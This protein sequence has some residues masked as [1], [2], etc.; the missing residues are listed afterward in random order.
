MKLTKKQKS[1][2]LGMV[3]GDGYLQATG[4]KNARLRLE[5]GIKQK[6]YLDWKVKNFPKLFQ[7]KIKKIN[8][9]HPVSKKVYS[10]ARHQSNS[11]PI[12]GRLR[13]IFYVDGSKLIPEYV[14]ENLDVLALAVWYMDDGYY[15]KRDKD[16]YIYIGNVDKQS[17]INA[18]DAIGKFDI[19][20]KIK[21][22]KKGF[23]LYFRPSET[24]KLSMLI[25]AYILP[26]FRYKLPS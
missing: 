9:L 2:L 1:I 3:L 15:Y 4:K 7:G 12:F 23:A 25:R 11:T 14:V 6:D 18:K 16:A 19:Q 5:H 26:E 8:R 22:K 13:S 21:S 24:L 20:V 10:Y 17:A